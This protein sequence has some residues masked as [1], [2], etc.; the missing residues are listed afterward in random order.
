MGILF[1]FCFLA[2]VPLVGP[3][4]AWLWSAISGVALVLT[5]LAIYRQLRLQRSVNARE[6]VMDLLRE[7]NGEL[8]TRQRLATVELLL[9]S[10]TFNRFTPA[11]WQVCGYWENIGILIQKGHLDRSILYPLLGASSVLWWQ[12]LGPVC[13]DMRLKHSMPDLLEPFEWLARDVQRQ[14][15]KSGVVADAIVAV[16]PEFLSELRE[17]ILADIALLESMRK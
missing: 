2:A 16:T 9:R 13:A 8:M 10:E 4:S 12:I 17:S 3:N 6:Q 5:L 1:K 11:I 14:N 7:Y 15:K